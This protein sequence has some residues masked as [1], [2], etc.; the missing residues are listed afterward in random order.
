MARDERSTVAD[1]QTVIKAISGRKISIT[2]SAIQ[3]ELKCSFFHACAVMNFLEQQGVISVADENGH[4]TY[5]A[6]A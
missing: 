2:T 1:I 6:G 5:N 4:R 3:R